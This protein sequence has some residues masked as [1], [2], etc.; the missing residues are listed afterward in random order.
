MPEGQSDPQ[1]SLWKLRDL[2]NVVLWVACGAGALSSLAFINQIA[3]GLAEI[4][5][6]G[7]LMPV[8]VGGMGAFTLRYFVHKSNR[9]LHERLE[10]EEVIRLELE[11]EVKKRTAD[12]KNSQ[13]TMRALADNLPEFITL[14]DSE[15]RFVFVNKRFEEW[16]GLDRHD[17]VGKTVHEIYSAEQ[18]AEFDALDRKVMT[19]PSVA[20]R[21]VDLLYPDGN[22]RAVISTRF[23]V[24]SS[25]GETIGLGTVNIDVSERKQAEQ[26]IQESEKNIRNVL[27]NVSQGVAM[28]DP[29]KNLLAWNEQFQEIL[30]HSE[31]MLVVGRSIREMIYETAQRG[32]YGEGETEEISDAR[33]DYLWGADATRSDLVFRN[34]RTYDVIAQRTQNDGLVITYTDITDRKRTEKEI[35]A[36]RDELEVLNQ[37]KDKFFSIIAHDLKGPFTSLL[38][39]SDLMVNLV[40]KVSREELAD[41]AESVNRGGKRVFDLLENLLEW[42]RL[43]LEGIDFEPGP[44]DLKE[45][46]DS[47]LLLFAPIAEEKKIMLTSNRT[48][49]LEAFADANMV[50]TIV[51]NLVNNAIKFTSGGGSITLTARRKGQWAEVEITDTGIGMPAGK[52][53]RLFRLDEKTSTVGT[54]GE[55]GTG[56]GLQLCK[57]LVE[58]QGGKIGVESTEGKGTTFRFTFP[59]AAP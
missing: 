24:V 59:N 23:P 26:T 55:T 17:V 3:T 6:F 5:A 11:L 22:T 47:N 10:L 58:R 38:G 13:E 54:S 8:L 51:R 2:P 19:D 35:E 25:S 34:D 40:G 43:Q 12:L 39:V 32:G 14:K 15:G 56:L 36:Q 1:R 18:A 42:S 46:I 28:F 20:S 21:E 31:G 9:L 52:V 27:E 53:S 57:E 37:Q 16:A 29:D 4:T 45:T 41:L 48:Q 44:I 33:V 49:P 30:Q 50:D 7:L